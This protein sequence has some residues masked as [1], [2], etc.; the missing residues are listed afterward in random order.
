[1]TE[2]PRILVT[3]ATGYIGG[4][5]IHHLLGA[6][7]VV[8]ALVREKARVQGKAWLEQVEVAEGDVLKDENLVAACTGVD[9]A[10]YLV[11][12]M[13]TSGKAFEADDLKAARNFAQAAKEAGVKHLVYLG[14]LG[15]SQKGM[16]EHLASRQATGRALA[17]AGVPTTEF[18]AAIIVGSGSVSF[19]MIRYLCE[20][21]PLMITPKWVGTR[22]QP[23]GIRDVLNYLAAAIT[24][25][26]HK[27]HQIVEIGGPD[28]LTYRAMM[29][30][31]AAIRG[32]HRPMIPVPVLSPTLS[33]YWVN[34]ITPIPASIARPLVEGL[35]SEVV[36]DDP[37]PAMA[38]GVTALSY[39]ETVKRALDRTQQGA[40]ETLWTDALGA[41]PRGAASADKLEDDQGMLTDKR[42]CEV[43]ASKENLYQVISKIGG[44]QGWYGYDWLWK[45][46]GMMDVAVG[47]VGL[48]RGRRDPEKLFPGD[49]IDFWRVESLLRYDH[50]QLRAEMKLPGRAWLRFD[51]HETSPKCCELRQTAFYEPKGFLGVGYW[52]AVYPLHGILFPNMLRNIAAQAE[53]LQQAEDDPEK[54][55]QDMEAS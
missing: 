4:R 19:E 11:H 45:L 17:E 32:L 37:Q 2:K 42:R 51:M 14:G 54:N 44:K 34:L 41:A 47:G 21:L 49:V 15:N 23:I 50:L 43:K 10:Y 28:V 26:P 35:R 16:S 52:W 53:A 33:S 48:R 1:M 46:R 8:R 55:E 5:L 18:R 39:R 40:V 31:Y 6:G 24:H 38:Y 3:G 30:G 36:V 9:T 22:V 27:P 13:N 29:Q 20:R 7:Y 12:S 25:P